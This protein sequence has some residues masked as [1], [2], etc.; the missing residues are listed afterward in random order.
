[1]KQ[2][3]KN[4]TILNGRYSV[5]G[6]LE[7]EE[8]NY[9][10]YLCLDGASKQT[11]IVKEFFPDYAQRDQQGKMSYKEEFE[12]D[13]KNFS[14]ANALAQKFGS[15]PTI[16]AVF[17]IFEQNNTSYAACEGFEGKSVY[18]LIK[19][20][21]S[22][23]ADSV[24]K[25]MITLLKTAQA[26]NKAG[27][28]YSGFSPEDVWVTSDGYIKLTD[29]EAMA[30][31]TSQSDAIKAVASVAY[32]MLTGEKAG[33]LAKSLKITRKDVSAEMAKYIIGVLSGKGFCSS[34]DEFLYD[35]NA[36]FKRRKKKKENMSIGENKENIRP[37]AKEKNNKEKTKKKAMII[38]G[39]IV[40]LL[41]IATATAAFFVMQG[42]AVE[43]DVTLSSLEY[44]IDEQES[45]KITEFTPEISIYNLMANEYK[46]TI[47]GVSEKAA[48][49]S[50]LPV[51]ANPNA[52]IELIGA[53]SEPQIFEKD[54]YKEIILNGGAAEFDIKITAESLWGIISK[55]STYHILCT[56][57][58]LPKLAGLSYLIG[59][60]ETNFENFAESKYDY[61]VQLENNSASVEIKPQYKEELYI[62]T[63]KLNGNDIAENSAVVSDG[64]VISVLVSDKND[65]NNTN[66]YTVVFSVKEKTEPTPAPTPVPKKTNTPKPVNAAT[67]KPTSAAPTPTP[68]VTPATSPATVS[69][70]PTPSAVPAATGSPEPTPM[71]TSATP[72]PTSVPTPAPTPVPTPV[73]TSAVTPVQ[74]PDGV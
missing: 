2:P 50:V 63:I 30:D 48:K 15:L 72:E 19:E 59:D 62:C 31:K 33:T 40:G 29:Y 21:R 12:S 36:G 6:T 11:V 34:V 28:A 39:I 3:L 32:F 42:V 10:A 16:P 25:V 55:S 67:A 41:V 37:A 68:A 71:P 35:I 74:S 61:Y 66:T 13:L 23:S 56:S 47:E 46:T 64:D 65:I 38:I 14:V 17:D 44:R 54:T 49:L 69:T 60:K 5:M 70:S 24:C 52:R 58:I 53:N 20:G 51:G 7:T 9:M 22:F 26:F 8:K 45:V 1:M 4:E 18:G 27:I 43:T 57:K 73:P